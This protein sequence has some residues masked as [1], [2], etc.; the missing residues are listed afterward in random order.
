MGRDGEVAETLGAVAFPL[1]RYERGGALFPRH[2][3]K[4]AWW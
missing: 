2:S 1:S 4:S 3:L